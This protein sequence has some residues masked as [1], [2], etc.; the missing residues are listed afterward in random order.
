MD[1]FLNPSVTE[2]FGNVTLEA[3]AAGVAVVAADATGARS[4]VED[5]VTGRLVAPLDVAAYADAIALYAAH[6][7]ALAAAGASGHE[8]AKTYEW[9]AV[10]Q[11]VVD[12]YL[13]AANAPAR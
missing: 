3:M 6:P 12:A 4:L 7:D 2:T 8:A 11:R 9:D 1:I 5:G 13:T 10:N